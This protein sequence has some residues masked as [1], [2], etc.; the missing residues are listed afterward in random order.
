MLA[1]RGDRDYLKHG[2]CENIGQNCETN[3]CT[4]LV[5]PCLESWQSVDFDDDCLVHSWLMTLVNT[6]MTQQ[7]EFSC[8]YAFVRSSLLYGNDAWTTYAKQ[9]KHHSRFHL[10]C[11]RLTL[12]ITWQEDTPNK[13]AF[14][15]TETPSMFALLSQRRLSWLDRICLT[16]DGRIPKDVF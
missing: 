14:K 8:A 15:R 16:E 13:D 10:R 12:A 9:V 3:K 5:A 11:L 4:T 2:V 6:E 1:C 7:T